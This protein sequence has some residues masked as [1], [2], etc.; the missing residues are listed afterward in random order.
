MKYGLIAH[1]KT[2][3]IGDDIQSYAMEKFLPHTDYLIDR[4]HLDSFYT[5]T[6]E[7]VAALLGGWYLHKPLNWP[8]SPFLKLLPISFHVTGGSDKNE[9]EGKSK[10]ALALTDYGATWLKKFQAV[11]CRDEGTVKLLETHGVPAYLSGCFTLTIGSFENVEPHGKIV[12]VDCKKSTVDF[13]KK[14]SKKEIV[15]VSHHYSL[16]QL[17]PEV[18]EF[19]A[20]H[21]KKNIIS[22][23]HKPAVPDEPNKKV[24]YKGTWSYRHALIEGLLRFYQGASLVV[25]G[26]LHAA[27][28]SV[29]LGTPVLMLK[30]AA[31]M[32]YYRFSTFLPYL[33]CTTPED[34]LSGKFSYD[35]DAPA[36]NPGGHEKFA[37]RIRTAC[38]AFIASCEN[39]MNTSRVDVE[40]WWDEQQKILR[41]KRLIQNF[42]PNAKPTNPE[43]LN[44]KAY[45]F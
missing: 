22:T 10:G 40:T 15:L 4:E 16:P 18:V 8:P 24:H 5:E 28:Q 3:N 25:T 36:P 19:A 12:L 30:S 20:K 43:L 41:L 27:L 37:E 34:L 32:T 44:P 17:P 45:K 11:G 14:H 1:F 6:G 13:V 21:D 31:D 26:R 42:M 7:K 29:A 9:L 39:D 38:S 33:N 23:S 2:R 35:F